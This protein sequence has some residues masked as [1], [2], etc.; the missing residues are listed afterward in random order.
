MLASNHVYTRLVQ[1]RVRLPSRHRI[2]ESCMMC[3]AMR[4]Y[5]NVWQDPKAAGGSFGFA[6]DNTIGGT[7]QANGWMDDWVSLPYQTYP[8]SNRPYQTY[9]LSNICHG[10]KRV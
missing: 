9:P 8:L 10:R 3:G 5:E 7:H 2:L 4:A 1:T 6:I